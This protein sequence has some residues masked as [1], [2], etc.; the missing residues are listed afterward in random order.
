MGNSHLCA[1][2]PP[3]NRRVGDI[4]PAQETDQH[5]DKKDYISDEGGENIDPAMVRM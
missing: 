4:F 3:D 5:K 1:K 2:E